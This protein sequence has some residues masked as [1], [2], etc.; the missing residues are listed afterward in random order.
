MLQTVQ[1]FF[2]VASLLMAAAAQRDST[3][4]WRLTCQPA[5]LAMRVVSGVWALFLLISMAHLLPSSALGAFGHPLVV[6][7][8][9]MLEFLLASVAF[10]LLTACGVVGRWVIAAVA[11]QLLGGLAGLV[12]LNWE[13]SPS[14]EAQLAWTAWHIPCAALVTFKV[15]RQTLYTSTRR[16]WLCLAACVMCMGLWLY[17]VVAPNS[18]STTLPVG[19]YVYAFFLFV[20]WKL[21]ALHPDADKA[22]ANVRAAFSGIGGFEPTGSVMAQDDITA[23]AVRCERQRIAYELHDNVGSQL[24]SILFSMQGAEHPPKRFVMLSLEQ[25]LSDLKMTVDAIHSFDESVT[26]ALGRLRYRV[27]PALDRQA[28][29]MR[30]S[31]DVCDTLD[32]VGGIYAQQVLRIAQESL[33]NVMRHADAKAVKVTCRYIP[34][35]CHLLLEVCDDGVGMAMDSNKPLAGRGLDA[36]KRRA[37]AIG[38]FL[39]ISSRHTRGTCVRLTLPLPHLKAA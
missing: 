16:G 22:L 37:S 17:Q 35:P 9:V 27:Q 15:M 10:F 3:R 34:E 13:Q 32:A 18:T 1:V 26:V 33:T 36:M 12:W 25:C 39:L 19:F 38:G 5:D 28:I 11:V 31:V 6:L 30:W 14:P 4:A 8:G 2:A 20:A 23:V 24:V 21:M 29:R 7:E